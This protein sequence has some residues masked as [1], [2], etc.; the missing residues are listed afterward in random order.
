MASERNPM[1][2]RV[3]VNRIWKHH[4]GRGLV[5]STDNFGKTGER[6]L[7]PLLLDYLAREFIAGGWSVKAMQRTIPLSSA[8]GMSA[9]PR[10]LEA[11]AI[12]D[13]I[14]AVSGSLD[15]K[16]YGPSV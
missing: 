2:A 10:R 13:N 16:M 5:A 15:P 7:D 11:E 8:Y 1:T 3:M 6:P 4:F 14:L 12:R 9:A